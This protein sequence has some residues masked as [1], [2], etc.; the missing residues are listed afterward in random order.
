MF[1]N[2]SLDVNTLLTGYSKGPRKSCFVLKD[3]NYFLNLIKIGKL[4]AHYRCKHKLVWVIH[5]QS[6][7]AITLDFSN[8]NSRISIRYTNSMCIKS[9]TSAKNFHSI[10]ALFYFREEQKT[11]IANT[12]SHRQTTG[13]NGRNG[14][15]CQL[16]WR[17]SRSAD[18][19]FRW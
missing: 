2:F 15:D 5:M 10:L 1:V 9:L 6:W 8:E 14:G 13:F 19:S 16:G 17:K 11:G 4:I 3:L 7:K 18:P 12:N